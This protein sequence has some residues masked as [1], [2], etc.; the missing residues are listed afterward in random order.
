MKHDSKATANKTAER[1]TWKRPELS[2][3]QAGQA[4]AALTNTTDTG[5]LS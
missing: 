5:V 3:Y 2:R 1:A 4:E